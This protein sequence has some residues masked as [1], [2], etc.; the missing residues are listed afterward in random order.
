MRTKWVNMGKAN[1]QCLAYCKYLI[2]V[3]VV[4]SILCI[5]CKCYREYMCEPHLFHFEK[6]CNRVCIKWNT[7]QCCWV[8]AV[9]TSIIKGDLWILFSENVWNVFLFM[10][11]T[12]RSKSARKFSWDV[13]SSLGFYDYL[14]LFICYSYFT[15]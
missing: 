8:K 15:V 6:Q 2:E 12:G 1:K 9:E 14:P 7:L 11:I 13:D 4:H 3:I 10:K 5:L